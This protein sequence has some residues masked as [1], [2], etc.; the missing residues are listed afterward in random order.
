MMMDESHLKKNVQKINA[1]YLQKIK[2]QI[3]LNLIG[4]K[5]LLMSWNKL[6]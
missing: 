3:E 5:S 6:I 2:V 1:V 4:V